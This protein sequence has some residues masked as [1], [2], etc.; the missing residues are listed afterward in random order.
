MNSMFIKQL[1]MKFILKNPLK[2]YF[3]VEGTIV[4][5]SICQ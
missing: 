4:T 3:V 1:H 2:K 5:V